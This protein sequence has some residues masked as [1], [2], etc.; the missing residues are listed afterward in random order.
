MNKDAYYIFDFDSTFIKLEGF[1]ELARIALS[2]DPNR[3]SKISTLEKITKDAMEG[4]LSFDKALKQRFA[5][6]SIS[7]ADIE[8]LIKVLKKSITP[9]ILRNRTFFKKNR[10][11]IFI[12]SGGFGEYIEPVAAR[13]GIDKSHILANSFVWDKKGQIVGFD[14]KNPLSKVGGKASALKKLKLSGHVYMIGEGYTDYEVKKMGAAST[15]VAFVEN[16]RR[17]NVVHHADWVV[18][19]LDEFLYKLHLPRAQSY[20]KNQIQVLLLEGIHPDAVSSF[21]QEGYKVVRHT[22]ALSESELLQSIENVSILG[23]RSQSQVSAKVLKSAKRLHAV[24]AYCIGTNQ[25]DLIEA[26]RVGTVCFNAPYSNTRSVVELTLGEMIMLARGVFDKSQN[27]HRGIWEKS[28]DGAIELRGK[29]LGIVGYGNIGSQL[30]IL[31]QNMGMDV[32]FYDIEDKLP[33]GNARPVKSLGALLKISDVVSVHVDGR[34]ANRNLIGAREFATMR[35]SVFFLNSSRGFVV[36]IEALAVAIDSGKVKGAAIDVHPSEPKKRHARYKSALAGLPNVI[37]TPHIAGSTAEAQAHIGAFVTRKLINFIN[38]GDTT[39]SVNFP[40][41]ALPQVRG[42][43]RFIHIHKNEPGVLAKINELLGKNNMNIEG[44]YLKT[45][46]NIGYVI[47]D[48]GVSYNKK[49][50]QELKNIP[51]TIKFRVLY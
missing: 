30:S 3:K 36:D 26:A 40:H 19:S 46:E 25:I 39:L 44:Q 8:M 28:A 43:H 6:L 2:A 31:A 9:S 34:A 51:E 29:T 33:L 20:P 1:D 22:H 18:G 24:G 38:T 48:V 35:D 23:I 49:I 11:R 10:D 15:F 42:A 47:T 12:L 16:V 21:E 14:T 41:L 13:F 37:L 45:N 4:K 32:Y 27:M 7:S 5:L 50:I 17:A